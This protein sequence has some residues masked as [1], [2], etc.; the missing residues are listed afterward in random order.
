M[1]GGCGWVVEEDVCGCECCECDAEYAVDCEE[2]GVESCDSS[3]VDDGVFCDEEYCGC[4]GCGVEERA[5]AW[6][7]C[8]CGDECDDGGCVECS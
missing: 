4:G 5:E 2:S 3:F 7:E 1:L 8:C 6:F